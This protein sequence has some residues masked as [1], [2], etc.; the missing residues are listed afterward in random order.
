M[1]PSGG[2]PPLNVTLCVA[3]EN[4]Q[5]TTAPTGTVSVA[6]VK[7]VPGVVT[8]VAED[9]GASTTVIVTVACCVLPSAVSSAVT[10]VVPGATPVTMPV[11]VT[12]AIA[13]SP[14]PNVALGSPDRT[15]P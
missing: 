8:V 12:V 14:D 6:G 9:G 5:V 1:L 3:P 11:P 4:C 10:V 2:A 15:L 13:T 7:L